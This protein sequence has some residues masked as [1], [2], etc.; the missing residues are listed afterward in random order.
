MHIVGS[1]GFRDIE[2]MKGIGGNLAIQAGRRRRGERA[3]EGK[4]VTHQLDKTRKDT[5]D[6]HAIKD[7]TQ[8]EIRTDT[9]EDPISN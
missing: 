3:G 5:K 7:E 6:N 1:Q 2:D 9:T 4:R 8:A